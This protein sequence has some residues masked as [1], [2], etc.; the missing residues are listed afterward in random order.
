[1]D[2]TDWPYG[3]GFL[4]D[5]GKIRASQAS[6]SFPVM[7]ESVIADLDDHGLRHRRLRRFS[8]ARL[9]LRSIRLWLLQGATEIAGDGVGMTPAPFGNLLVRPSVLSQANRGDSAGVSGAAVLIFDV[10]FQ[11]I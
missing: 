6:T 1:M 11:D 2:A 4:R 5:R 7:A 3:A 9:K 8:M 10:Q